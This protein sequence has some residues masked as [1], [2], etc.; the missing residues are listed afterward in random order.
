M[1]PASK[2]DT[3]C[4]LAGIIRLSLS[5]CRFKSAY[6]TPVKGDK[7]DGFGESVLIRGLAPAVEEAR[8]AVVDVARE[9]ANAS[10]FFVNREETPLKTECEVLC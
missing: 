6:C 9:E 2:L 10:G 3:R 1:L 7:F 4:S 5:R 8:A